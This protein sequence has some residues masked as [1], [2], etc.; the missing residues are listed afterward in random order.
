MNY[1]GSKRTLLPFI[2]Q[3]I[4]SIAGEVARSGTFC[5]LFAGTGAV[6]RFYKLQG[7]SV[8]ANDWQ[9]YGFVLNQHYIGTCDPLPFLGLKDHIPVLTT[10]ALPERG[11]VVCRFLED[12]PPVEGFVSRHFCPGGLLMTL[13]KESTSAMPTADAAMPSAGRS[14][15][16]CAR[17]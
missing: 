3:C 15:R 8:T 12:L 6:G 16:G 17:E 4:T 13:C 1:I 11:A 9:F 14:M 10:T 7:C 2:D 5:D